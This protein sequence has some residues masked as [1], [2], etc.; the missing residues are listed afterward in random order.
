LIKIESAMGGRFDDT[1]VLGK[2]AGFAFGRAG[3]DT[4]TGGS[5]NDELNGGSGA[6]FIDGGAGVDTVN[7]MD[8]GYDSAGAGTKGVNVNLGTGKARDNWGK[9][10]TLANVENVTGSGLGDALTGDA[11]RNTG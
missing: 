4:L 11:G 10:D 3:N 6:D 7:F 5:A 8:D 2:R 9:L 1:L